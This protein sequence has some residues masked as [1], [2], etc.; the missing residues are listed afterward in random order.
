MAASKFVSRLAEIGA[1]I[2]DRKEFRGV[3]RAFILPS[4]LNFIAGLLIVIAVMSVNSTDIRSSLSVKPLLR[5]SNNGDQRCRRGI[6]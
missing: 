4:R 3:F 5:E 1:D 6:I 2:R